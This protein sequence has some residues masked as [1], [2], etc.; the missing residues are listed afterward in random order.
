MK[1]VPPQTVI[2]RRRGPR[3]SVRVT[4][5]TIS[6]MREEIRQYYDSNGYLSWS[7]KR[8]KYVI[9]GT[10]QPSNGLVEC[11]HCRVGKILVIRSRQTRKRFL[12]CSNY[13]NGCSASSP[14]VQRGMLYATKTPCKSCSWPVVL[15]RYSRRQKWS[16]QCGNIRCPGRTVR[17]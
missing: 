3:N 5:R 16:R 4:D 8:G 11:P 13:H 10:N 14:L 17:P 1:G 15:V 9:L 7:E 6:R 12:G 2:L